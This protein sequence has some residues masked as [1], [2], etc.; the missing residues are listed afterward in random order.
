MDRTQPKSRP[1][2]GFGTAATAGRR[3]WPLPAIALIALAACQNG[4]FDPD[5]RG[6]GRGGFSTT[7]AA[8]SATAD[9]PTPD[10]RGVISYPTYQVAVAQRGD[11]VRTV[12]ARVGVNADALASYN[13]VSPDAPLSLGEVLALPNRVN[14]PAG[15]AAAGTTTTAT[16]GQIDISSIASSAIGRASTGTA[17]AAGTTAAA[18]TA[19]STGGT[20]TE[21][22]R[23]RVERGE[24]A[25][26]IARKYNVS[27]KSLADWNGLSGDMSVREGQYLLIPVA[28]AG[29]GTNAPGTQSATPLPPS[30]AKPLPA[31]DTLPA[32]AP[33][34]VVASP[35]MGAQTTTASGAQFVMPVPGSIIRGYSKGKNDGIDISAAAGTAVKAADGGTVAAITKDTDQVPIMVIRHSNNLLTVYANIDDITV[36]KG[37][38]VSR[39]Q[40]I[41]KVRSGGSPFLHFEVRDGYDSVD[42]MRYLQ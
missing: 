38:T 6:F 28:L 2:P 22:V 4:S 31:Q 37:A 8:Q 39:G 18:T 13:A 9:R 41:A 15:T 17:I 3:I 24:T 21:P 29:S 34:P 20:G 30:A 14:E 7:G 40:T 42:P 32:S 1:T 5:L 16:P 19:P 25:Y 11:T 12:A 36:S 23:H 26:T 33:A 10:S 27:V 35:N